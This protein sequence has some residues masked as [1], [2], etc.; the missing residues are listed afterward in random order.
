MIDCAGGAREQ[1]KASLTKAITWASTDAAGP[2]LPLLRTALLDLASI[3]VAEQA[4]PAAA[5]CLQAAA[6]AGRCLEQL[7]RAPQAL[8][9][10]TASAVP[11]WAA[12]LLQGMPF[13]AVMVAILET[14]HAAQKSTEPDNAVCT[15][16]AVSGNS[17]S[18]S[19]SV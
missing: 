19:A 7:L 9:P 5:A 3:H 2:S 4:V 15:E 8:G 14:A 1:G 13:T 6:V 11:T 12:E 16:R 10:A 18:A 17:A